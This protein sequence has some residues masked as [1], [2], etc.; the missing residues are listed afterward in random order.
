MNR[1]L[2]LL[3]TALAWLAPAAQAQELKASSKLFARL[4]GDVLRVAIEVRVDPGFHLYHGPTQADA[5][6]EGAP[7]S[8]TSVEF[9]AP[10]FEIESL[11]FP[12][13][14]PDTLSIGE[15]RY[16]VYEHSGTFALYAWGK[17]T[18]SEAKLE[19][20]SATIRGLTCD[21]KGCTPYEEELQPKGAGPDALFAAMPARGG[22]EVK[23]ATSAES[24][25]MLGLGSAAG[26]AQARPFGDDRHAAAQLFAR[27]KD[28]RVEIAI[29]VELE[30][31]W[32]LYHGPTDKDKGSEGSSGLPTTVEFQTTE[33]TLEPLVYPKPVQATE[34]IGT[35]TY[36]VYEHTGTFVLRT[37]GKRVDNAGKL[38]DLAA[39]I[40][41]L[42]C[43]DNGVCVQYEQELAFAGAG[44]DALFTPVAESAK[45]SASTSAGSGDTSS[46][47]D[48]A[49]QPGQEE[50]GLWLFLLSAVGWGLFTLLM[51]CTYP[52][53]PITISYFTKQA[54]QR[55]GSTLPLSL[56][57]GV[58][59][60]GTF[61]LIGLVVGPPIVAFASHPVT[62]LVIGVL[63]LYF[64]LTLFGAVN[65]QP[66]AFLLNFAGQASSKGGILG[67]FLMGATLVVTSFTCTAPFVG[68]LLSAGASSGG[69]GRVA[70]GMAVFG[71]TMA[72]PF[73]AL[74]MLPGKAKSMPKSGEWMHTIK[75][76]LGFVEIAA[77]M[78]F[79]SNVDLVW[80]WGWLSR[81]LFLFLWVAIFLAAALYLFGQIR[82]E[83]EAVTE[84][85]PARMSAG[86]LFLLLTA[87]C[88][89]GALG[90][91]LDPLMT[92]IIP[93]YS[94]RSEEPAA[95]GRAQPKRSIVIDDYEKAL[96]QARD[97]NKL[98]LVN[99][100]GHV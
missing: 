15:E 11:L 21:A 42:T 86:L 57:Y 70:L 7:A 2:L 29:E 95:V 100:T 75:V 79:I 89:Y 5:G 64:S 1:A 55:Q 77:A 71:A 83:N 13:P 30:A 17:R 59:I 91:R 48:S 81:E 23:P 44:N 98:L 24:L 67:V 18:R 43:K 68:T 66:P 62:N 96:A 80:Q 31:G 54:S 49:A 97:E 52:M 28:G 85:S 63:F 65:L 99:F 34:T 45:G 92:A 72:V 53:I 46:A 8:P 51:P 74:S 22:A 50:L 25:P 84:V 61:V 73:V 78:K 58:G 87:Y 56:A 32:H 94:N 47:P 14:H 9:D 27:E 41:G 6:S 33:F 60:V 69:L 26:A 82:L 37:R 36:T 39:T 35:D 20:L 88:G 19:E 40:K 93:P 76:T 12:K 90:N 10:G 4:E 3:A 16:T 38:S